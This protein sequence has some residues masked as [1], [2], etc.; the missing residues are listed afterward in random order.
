MQVEVK[1][2]YIPIALTTL[3]PGEQIY[4]EGGLMVYSDPTIGFGY[5]WLTQGGVAATL[6]RT[7]VGGLPFQLHEYTGPGYVAFSRFRPGETRV[8]ELE[9]GKAVDVA[10]HSLLLAT[11]TIHYDTFYVQGTGRIG[12]MIGFWMDRLTGPGTFAFQGHGN[13]LKFTLAQ[14]EAM[15]IDHGAL[16]M[17]DASVTVRAYNQP[18]GGGLVGHALSFEALRVEGPGEIYLQTIDPSKQ[19]PGGPG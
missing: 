8:V 4:C 3:G 1:G 19:A 10:E 18:L 14:G 6:K 9:A 16:V 11:S 12:R 7:L 5:R 13:I 15:D 17:K 2:D